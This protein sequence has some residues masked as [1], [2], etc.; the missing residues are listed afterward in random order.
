MGPSPKVRGNGIILP[1]E[2][3][4]Q[5]A[6]AL[7]NGKHQMLASCSLS[8]WRPSRTKGVVLQQDGV[9]ADRRRNWLN[10]WIILKRGYKKW[11]LR[12]A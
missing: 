9:K 6:G 3:K 5:G 7:A 4:A 10:E 2:R 1:R 8:P 12:R 11:E